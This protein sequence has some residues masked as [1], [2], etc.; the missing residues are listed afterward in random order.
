MKIIDYIK[1]NGLIL[2]VCTVYAAIALLPLRWMD[3]IA[4]MP[5]FLVFSKLDSQD[6][7]GLIIGAISSI[8][9]VMMAV[10][11]LSVEFF[12]EKLNKNV[13]K[14]PL[15]N[16][17]VQNTIF[18]S[19]GIISISFV[20]YLLIDKFDN[21]KHITLG[22][23]I[24]SLFVLYIYSV[25]P[26]FKNIIDSSSQIKKVLDNVK[27]LKLDDFKMIT[28]YSYQGKDLDARLRILKRDID[29]YILENKTDS[30]EAI[31]KAILE[32]GVKFIGDGTNR[33]NCE[34]ILGALT[35]IWGENCKTAIR[36]G[37]SQYFDN[38][39]NSINSVYL[40]FAE[41]KINLLHIY[42]VESFIYFDL[43]N[44]YKH[45]KNTI[46]LGNALNVIGNSFSANVSKNCPN[47]AD[48]WG[49]MNLYE[50]EE[51]RYSN[52]TATFTWDGI[53]N[54]INYIS[55]I[56]SIAI[57]LKDKDLF[58]ECNQRISIMCSNIISHLNNL[59]KYQKG[60]LIRS[61]II[62]SYYKSSIALEQGLYN[63][64]LDC[65]E[66]YDDLMERIIED[67]SIDLR[68]IRLII[69]TLG[70][71]LFTALKNKTLYSN[72]FSGT[73][74]DF[75]R[76]GIHSLKKYNTS[77]LNEKV[78]DYCFNFFKEAKLYIEQ[79]SMENYSKEYIDVQSAL[80]HLIEV[81]VRLD[82]FPENES[83]VKEWKE[84]LGSFINVQIESR[85]NFDWQD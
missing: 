5:D 28:R 3:K 81:A 61:L 11:I 67:E 40:Y 38:V 69:S 18:L 36:V 44:L 84:E 47:Q 29:A 70:D 68:D 32:E 13:F 48:I 41:R 64:T 24:A 57:E 23:Y 26:F 51:N 12:K 66:V 82:S 30:Y 25:F 2:S 19:V 78:V 17:N 75:C 60:D 15:E 76:I 37:D 83:P 7:F 10:I 72:Y 50:N 53:K 79:N 39:W 54:I 4:F 6:Y 42:E 27:S 34:I 46:S 73:F 56:Q 21:S 85:F 35:W 31:N 58:E 8:F 59:G 63:N 20:S 16:R 74:R 55:Y 49:L 65:Y 1:K 14:S 62:E 80:T 33:D 52:Y 45:F 77:T 9:G 43:K 71:F 22:Y